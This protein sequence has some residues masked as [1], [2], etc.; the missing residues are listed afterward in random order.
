MQ[1]LKRRSRNRSKV[2]HRRAS[3]PFDHDE[4]RQEDHRSEKPATPASRPSRSAPLRKREHET[5]QADDEDRDAEEVET[6]LLAAPGHL[7]QHEVRPR[8]EPIRPSGTLNQKTHGQAIA[9]S[10]PPSTGPITSPTA[11]AWRSSPSRA[12][13]LARE[14]V[15][16]ESCGVRE[17]EGATDALQ[18][19]ARESA[20]VPLP[21]KPAPNEARVKTRKPRTYACFRPKRSESRP[22][23]S[24]S[25]V[26]RSC[27]RGSPR[28][29]AAASCAGCA[30]DPAAR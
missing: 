5:R 24:T 14:C 15:G 22:A 12:R 10:A 6:V 1:Q 23:V 18:R 26:E 16:D 21:A 7:V 28:R 2:E 8:A 20:R 25:T 19:R 30:R 13:A 11:R 9:T 29:A 17:E 4:E 3:A 27:T